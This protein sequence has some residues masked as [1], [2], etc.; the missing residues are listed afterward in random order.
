MAEM[1]Y[2]S[3]VVKAVKFLLDNK[4]RWI[5]D[6]EITNFA[7]QYGE[8]IIDELIKLRD[9]YA[10]KNGFENFLDYINVKKGR[11]DYGQK[12]ILD[13]CSKHVAKYAMPRELEFRDELPKTLV[14]K[15]A[16]RV[17]EEEEAAKRADK[18]EEGEQ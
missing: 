13:Y 18:K 15:V 8:K 14:G 6:Y 9:T 7:P 16:Y 4:G 11:F 17:L 1:T 2:G 5:T 3:S 12:E 10:R